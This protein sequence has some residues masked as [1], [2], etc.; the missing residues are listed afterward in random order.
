MFDLVAPAVGDHGACDSLSGE[1]RRAKQADFV[2][3]AGPRAAVEGLDGELDNEL[4]GGGVSRLRGVLDAR[5][6]LGRD[7]D[8]LL[9]GL[10]HV[11]IVPEFWPAGH[12]LRASRGV[13]VA[14]V[15]D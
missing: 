8:V 11:P 7:A 2:R 5:P 10:G 1:H 4:V 6:L 14:W 9:K 15:P 12:A 13:V 3:G